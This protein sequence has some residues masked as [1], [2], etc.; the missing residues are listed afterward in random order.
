MNKMTRKKNAASEEDPSSSKPMQDISAIL[1]DYVSESELGKKLKKF[2]IFNHW[3]HIVGKEISRK[4]KPQKLFKKILYISV[5]DP[6]WANELS[7]MSEKLI[8]KINSYIGEEII[9]QL[10]FKIMQ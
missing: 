7:M 8:E 6:G 1:D 3:E 4:T 2:S 10:R 5:S 9:S